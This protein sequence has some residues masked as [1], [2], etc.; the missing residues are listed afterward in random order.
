MTTPTSGGD[1]LRVALT[2]IGFVA[3]TAAIIY[4]MRR[5]PAP[6]G[7]DEDA[8]ALAAS[9]KSAADAI[10]WPPKPDPTEGAKIVG[11]ETCK[12]C[13]EDKHKLLMTSGHSRTFARTSEL[14][15]AKSLHGQ[16]FA[17]PERNYTFRY[18]FD[19]KTGLSVSI[20]G[21]IDEDF[22]LQFAVGSGEH[23]VTFLGI[24]P[25]PAV[26]GRLQPTPIEHRVTVYPH[27]KKNRLN[28]SP[29]HAGTE[30]RSKYTE[31]GILQ[32]D[33]MTQDCI[34]CH[35]TE[36]TL[37]GME[38]DHL[39]ANVTCENCHGPGSKHVAEAESGATSPKHLRLMRGSY[40]A[41]EQ[42]FACG[43]CHRIPQRVA[44]IQRENV[45][46]L[47][48]QPVGLMQSRCFKETKGQLS[49]TLCHDPHGAVSHDSAAYIAK[50]QSCHEPGKGA[51][52]PCPVSPQKD[53]IRC[54][55]PAIQSIQEVAFTDHWIRVRDERDA[56][57][58]PPIPLPKKVRK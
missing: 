45:D 56:L 58:N 21:K 19:P 24:A 1:R 2:V 22:P 38:I 15:L 55:M 57:A 50:C 12:S 39:R 47:R 25:N 4:A 37:A 9:Q 49:C 23:G 7:I 48:F 6:P 42:M 36:G 17:D 40:T 35:T 51:H 34:A 53:C 5:P 14:E 44:E 33:K 3:A 8:A 41:E 54:H 28:L 11:V 18:K 13:H 46:F 20:P 26:D 32:T 10:K 29:S 30:I 31:F 43:Q 52:T 16:T 27:A